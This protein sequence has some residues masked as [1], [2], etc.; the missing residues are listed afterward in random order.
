M[1]S[2]FSGGARLESLFD[3]QLRFGQIRTLT[4]KLHLLMISDD[5][6]TSSKQLGLFEYKSH[7][8]QVIDL[9]LFLFL[10]LETMCL[11]GLHSL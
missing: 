7:T 6:S 9:Q 8:Q 10:S 3:L 11:Q 2:T 1:L 4:T 5:L